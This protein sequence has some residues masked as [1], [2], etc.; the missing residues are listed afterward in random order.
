[1]R[2]FSIF[3]F[4]ISLTASLFAQ[5]S[6]KKIQEMKDEANVLYYLELANTASLDRFYD[7]EYK[8]AGIKGFFSYKDKDSIRTIFFAMIDTTD[9]KF[10]QLPDSVRKTFKEEVDFINIVHSFSY[11]KSINKK[12]A[13]IADATRR[14]TDL[15]HKLL[16]ARLRIFKEF[17]A[18]TTK[19]KRYMGTTIDMLPIDY[20]KTFRIYLVTLPNKPG[21]VIFGNDYCF[22]LDKKTNTFTKK[23]K[24]HEVYYN[25]SPKYAGKKSDPVKY[26]FHTHK[27]SDSPYMTITDIFLLMLYNKGVEWEQHWVYSKKWVSTYTL[28][29]QNLVIID[30]KTFEKQTK[31]KE[32]DPYED[33]DDNKEDGH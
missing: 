25:I 29:N 9:P 19:Y 27:E 10:R 6:S 17:D 2:S 22:E 12:N 18:D 31:P 1:M 24:L 3:I 23:E 7:D 28:Y 30:R 15:E 5:P 20:N 21:V 8:S 11:G 13:V 14:P 16:D 32:K 26:T 4:T 33:P